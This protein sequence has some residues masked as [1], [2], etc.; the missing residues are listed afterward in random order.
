MDKDLDI[1]ADLFK[2]LADPTRLGL[3]KLLL[4]QTIVFCSGG[5]DGQTFL[6]VGALAD[7]LKVTQSAVS[8]HLRILRQVGLVKGERRGAFMHY[9]I[10]PE[11]LEK[12]RSMVGQTMGEKLLS[13]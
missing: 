3:V 1:L 5:C 2:A 9:S 4:G 7:K 11:G 6:C 8:Q 10:D 13:G 12:F